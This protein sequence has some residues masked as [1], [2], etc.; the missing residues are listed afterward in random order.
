MVEVP[1]N[2]SVSKEMEVG[3]GIIQG[4]ILYFGQIPPGGFGR[5]ELIITNSDKIPLKLRFWIVGNASELVSCT[6]NG[7]TIMPNEKI[8]ISCTAN[9]PE[10]ATPSD[11]TGTAIFEF[12]K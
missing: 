11:W 3:V 10:N 7:S 1:I 12:I 9:I 4:N 6:G 5:R 2:F 8:T